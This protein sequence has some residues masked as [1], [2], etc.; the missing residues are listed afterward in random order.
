MRTAPL[1]PFSPTQSETQLNVL[2]NSRQARMPFPA[3][4]SNLRL[5]RLFIVTYVSISDIKNEMGRK[6][7]LAGSR[8][9][10][11]GEKALP[12]P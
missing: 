3:C 9:R 7:H 1:I 2:A 11:D 12:L 5:Q 10:K 8:W 6:L 4:L